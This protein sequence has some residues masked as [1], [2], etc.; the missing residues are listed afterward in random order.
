MTET[1]TMTA[2]TKKGYIIATVS[3][4]DLV[5]M[6]KYREV[7]TRAMQ[8]HNAEVLVRGGAMQVLE[9][10]WS[11]ERVIVLAFDSVEKAKTFHYSET[12]QAAKEIRKDAGVMRMIV[13]EG[14]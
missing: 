14:V 13:V 2:S 9:G 12:Y 6:G 3:V 7:S 1:T 10:D 11:P 5:Q 8:E 4:T